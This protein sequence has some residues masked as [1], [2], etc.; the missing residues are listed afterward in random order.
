GVPSNWEK[1]VELSLF[2]NFLV[3]MTDTQ[4][5]PQKLRVYLNDEPIDAKKI[6]KTY[7]NKLNAHKQKKDKPNSV[8]YYEVLHDDNK[9]ICH[10]N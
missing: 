6:K 1:G 9:I 5:I 8:S 3:S 10:L 2:E 7:L 4:E